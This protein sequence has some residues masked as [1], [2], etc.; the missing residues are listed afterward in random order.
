MLI[1]I[2]KDGKERIEQ[3]SIGSM[4]GGYNEIK[5]IKTEEINLVELKIKLQ[6][7][8]NTNSNIGFD[9]VSKGRDN[10]L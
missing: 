2:K 9:I 7:R 1:G 8:I 4:A 10:K 5:S 6:L 3:L